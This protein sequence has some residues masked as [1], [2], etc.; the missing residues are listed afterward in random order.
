MHDGV[1]Y[2][3]DSKFNSVYVHETIGEEHNCNFIGPV[4][5]TRSHLPNSHNKSK[6]KFGYFAS[7]RWKRRVKAMKRGDFVQFYCGNLNLTVWKDKSVMYILDN[8]VNPD[9]FAKVTTGQHEMIVPIVC[10]LYRK[11]HSMVD[12]AN[13]RRAAFGIERRSVRKHRNIFMGLAEQLI[14]VNSALLWADIHQ[15]QRFNA[16]EL[17]TEWVKNVV[18]KALA[19]RPNITRLKARRMTVSG[20]RDS[21][22]TKPGRHRLIRYVSAS[23]NKRITCKYCS[24]KLKKRSVTYY[25]CSVCEVYG[26]PVGFCHPDDGDCFALWEL[27]D[28]EHSDSD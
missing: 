12:I 24:L 18:R 17:R 27:H 6:T 2:V 22:M 1:I 19:L 23:K 15:K 14:F 9:R 8:C 28:H 5:W 25:R 7:D 3:Q 4:V 21:I 10:H 20:I 26:N 11:H 13:E 16:K